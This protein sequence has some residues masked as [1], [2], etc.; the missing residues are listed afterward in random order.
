MMQHLRLRRHKRNNKKRQGEPLEE[1]GPSFAGRKPE[2]D[3][4]AKEKRKRKYT[5]GV[6]SSEEAGGLRQT[7]LMTNHLNI[8][9]KAAVKFAEKSYDECIATY[10]ED[11]RKE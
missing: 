11:C 9:N 1:I 4:A 6:K 2:E 7:L 10:L 3:K 8:S 5:S